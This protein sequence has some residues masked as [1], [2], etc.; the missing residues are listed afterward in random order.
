MVTKSTKYFLAVCGV[1]LLSPKLLLSTGFDNRFLPFFPRTVIQTVQERSY[2]KVEPFFMS[3]DNAHGSADKKKKGIPEILGDFDLRT[4]AYASEAVGNTNQLRPE[5]QTKF[6]ILWNMHGKIQGQGV[7]FAGEYAFYNLSCGFSTA[8]MHLSSNQK[9]ILPRKTASDMSLTA[10]DEVELDDDRRQTLQDLGFTSSEWSDS[11]LTDTE[12]F[13]RYGWVKDY[14]LKC[15]QAGCGVKAGLILHSSKQRDPKKPASIPFGGEG[16]LG[17]FWGLDGAFEIKEDLWV[18]CM[19]NISSRLDKVQVRR[20]P[21]RGESELFG[22]TE[23][24]VLIDPGVTLLF[25]PAVTFKKIRDGF[26]F[27]LQYV[28]NTHSGDVWQD[29][30][31]DKSIAVDFSN[32]YKRSKWSSEY[33]LCNVFYDYGTLS[34]TKKARPLIS[35]SWDIP[36]KFIK[37][38]DSAKTHRVGVSVE[39]RF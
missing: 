8:F 29:E 33:L 21:V 36:I 16:M 20:L 19:V 25:S 1:V 35:F 17:L 32:I 2:L 37:Q 23:G 31:A 12:V 34:N 4:L 30:R 28:L 6:D 7:K 9:F 26:G 27:Q 3:G 5:W 11:T 10:A 18:S 15:R 14:V 38:R 22:A 13:L 39:F 24:A